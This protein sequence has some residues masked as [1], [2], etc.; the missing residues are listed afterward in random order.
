MMLYLLI[1]AF[2]DFTYNAPPD[3]WIDYARSGPISQHRILI[4]E[5]VGAK[6]DYSQ[7]SHPKIFDES[8]KFLYEIPFATNAWFTMNGILGSE[9]I[10]L[11]QN[12]NESSFMLWSSKYG[13][14]ECA[15][16]A[17]SD[18]RP[19]SGPGLLYLR[20]ISG[21]RLMFLS[22]PITPLSSNAKAAH[23]TKLEVLD[24]KA[25]TAQDLIAS[26]QLPI[27]RY[28]DMNLDLKNSESQMSRKW[29]LLYR[30]LDPR[31]QYH[32]VDLEAAMDNG[33]P[34]ESLQTAFQFTLLN[35]NNGFLSYVGYREQLEVA[36][37]ER[38]GSGT[39]LFALSEADKERPGYD[40]VEEVFTWAT[41]SYATLTGNIITFMVGDRLVWYDTQQNQLRHYIMGPDT[42]KQAKTAD[43][44]FSV[45]CTDRVITVKTIT[46]VL[47]RSRP[48]PSLILDVSPFKKA[49]LTP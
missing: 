44:E 28:L 47:K 26:P 22:E 27:E 36:V 7:G 13:S 5:M 23:G 11:Y 14:R 25:V 8:G 45:T 2:G 12:R 15:L 37:F 1:L 39:H 20:R 24:L 41:S 38:M 6:G 43:S 31:R 46:P 30:F 33:P 32:A 9:D 42:S 3:R 49:P 10:Y 16:N 19:G 34:F 21:Q 29:L 18:V 40:A 4:M 17:K 35:E 48:A